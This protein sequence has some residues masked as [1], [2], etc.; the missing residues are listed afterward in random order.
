MTPRQIICIEALKRAPLTRE[1]CGWRFAPRALFS[2]A[3]V[4]ALVD[5]GLAVREGNQVRMP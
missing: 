4:R 1:T 5:A 3:T 2:F